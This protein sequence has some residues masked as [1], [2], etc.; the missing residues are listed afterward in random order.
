M[1]SYVQ[2]RFCHC[3]IPVPV[4]N[5]TCVYQLGSLFPLKEE[6]GKGH[7][8]LLVLNLRGIQLVK[9]VLRLMFI[10][11]LS[12]FLILIVFQFIVLY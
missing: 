6:G 8:R 4:L 2:W 9:F 11:V 3:S 10:C 1:V 5:C 12:S 7:V